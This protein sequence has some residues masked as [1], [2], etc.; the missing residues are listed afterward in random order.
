M[1]PWIVSQGVE[2]APKTQGIVV[3]QRTH[4]SLCLPAFPRILFVHGDIF[5]LTES[6]N[7]YSWLYYPLINCNAHERVRTPEKMIY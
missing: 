6:C 4:I 2:V 1:V 3:P 7:F 5:I